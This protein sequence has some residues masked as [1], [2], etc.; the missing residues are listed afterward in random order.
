MPIRHFLYQAAVL[1]PLQHGALYV[2]QRVASRI[3]QPLADAGGGDGG[4]LVGSSNQQPQQFSISVIP[5][6][7]GN[8]PQ[9]L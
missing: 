1:T 6:S 7:S 4:V 8:R 5:T 2:L 9:P 3:D